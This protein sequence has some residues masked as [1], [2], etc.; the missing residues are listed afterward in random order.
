MKPVEHRTVLAEAV[1]RSLAW[2]ESQDDRPVGPPTDAVSLLASS[3]VDELPNAGVAPETAVAEL[4]GWLEPGLSALGSGRYLA[5]VNGG[6][7]PAALAADWLVSA[8]DQHAAF[9]QHGPAPIAAE[10]VAGRWLLD[11]LGLP[12]QAAVGFP[13]GAQGANTIGLLAARNHVSAAHGVDVE[14]SGVAAAPPITVI[15]GS[16]LHSSI[17]RSVRAI[18]LGRDAIT[19]VETDDV[20][21]VRADAARNAIVG[22]D[23]P[24]IVCAQA[25]NVNAGGF[26]PLDALADAVDERRARRD[27][28]WLHVDGAFGLWVRASGRRRHLAAGAERA[29]S[30]A[31]DAHKWLNTPYDCGIS[32]VANAQTLARAVGVRAAYLPEEGEVADAS[33]RVLEFSRRA[34]GVPVWAALRSLGRDGVEQ[35]VDGA[36][37]AAEA[38][39]A[40]VGAL[41]GV[42][43]RG[44]AINQVVVEIVDADGRPDSERTSAVLDAVVADGRCY[45][46]ATVWQGRPGIRLSVSNW[47]TDLDDARV[48]ADAFQDALRM[49]E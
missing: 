28:V 13:T 2:L 10:H 8:W 12:P 25:G 33:D 29:D 5:L 17:G 40:A 9:A 7:L 6:S 48:V 15:A 3:P 14:Q 20:G 19:T 26:D 31:C 43:V 27:D 49:C 32:I 4:A 45:P 21:A 35:L 16:E 46:S 24:V 38:I 37:D 23:G 39:A 44:Q 42:Q 1:E 34:R 36:C 22:A 30:W 47:R 41:D 11:L 18:G